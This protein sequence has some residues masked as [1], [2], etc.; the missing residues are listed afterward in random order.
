MKRL[1]LLIL[2]V[3]APATAQLTPAQLGDVSTRPAV[4]ARLPGE[5]RLVDERGRATTLARVANGRPLALVFADYDC[6][7]VCGPGM[8]LTAAA[9]AET[10][11]APGRDYRLAV[12]GLDPRDDAATVE[13]MR[14]RLAPPALAR[15]AALL[16]GDAAAVRAATG[17][18]GYRYVYDAS[19]GQF[20]HDASV[21]VFGGDGRLRAV[22]PE[23]GLRA[24][25]LRAAL[26]GSAPVGR[27]SWSERIAHLCYGL[28]AAHGRY[29]R[30]VGIGLQLLTVAL[31]AAAAVVILRRRRVA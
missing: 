16:R 2:L 25:V 12:I 5:I 13:R 26:R 15:D 11:L 19:S 7:H 31:A 20:A 17:A 28:A 4:D 1:L 3:G 21:L 9:L 6:P 29:G 27:A 14:A 8:V 23:L 10:G 22:L 24:D 30:A 18:L